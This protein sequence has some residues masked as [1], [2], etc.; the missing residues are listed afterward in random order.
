[1]ESIADKV[2]NEVV[3]KISKQ[4]NLNKKRTDIPVPAR[5]TK[6]TTRLTVNPRLNEREKTSKFGQSVNSAF[7]FRKDKLFHE[8]AGKLSNKE[9][10]FST[11]PKIQKKLE[12]LR[13]PADKYLDNNIKML[14][15]EQPSLED[16]DQLLKKR[17]GER[18]RGYKK[19]EI[20]GGLGTS[21]LFNF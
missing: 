14:H 15:S 17:V 13:K 5:P 10:V 8:R 12:R 21:L 2:A 11:V 9:T 7:G 4:L 3:D 20:P 18:A 19:V 6:V 16:I 1:M